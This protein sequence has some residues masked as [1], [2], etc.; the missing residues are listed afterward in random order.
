MLNG[1]P[2]IGLCMTKI[3]EI[4]RANLVGHLHRVVD[5]AGMKLIVFNSF[6]DFY[7]KDDFDEG[8]RYVYDIIQF[9]VVDVLVIHDLSFF[10]KSIVAE[11]VDRARAAGKP[12]VIIN[13]DREG[14]FSVKANFEEAFTTV[15]DHVFSHHG[16]TDSYF[17][18]LHAFMFPNSSYPISYRGYFDDYKSESKEEKENV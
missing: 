2:V 12:V 11:L 4:G 15:I 6:V 5:D 13:G 7:H 10:Q 8:S 9:D 17:M 18:A 1:K 14:C 16:V 3:H